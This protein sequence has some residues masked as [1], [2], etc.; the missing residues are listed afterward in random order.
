MNTAQF[1]GRR[2]LRALG[3]VLLVVILVFCA[4]R[5]VPGDPAIL[6]L[7]EQARDSDILRFQ[8]ATHLN[9]PLGIQLK[10]YLGEIL[11]G[12]FGVPYASYFDAPH[13]STLLWDRLPYTLELALAALLIASLIAFP[14]GII[15]ALNPHSALDKL[16]LGFSLM[17]V[18]IP[19]FWLG[20]ILL[21]F[22]SVQLGW[23][24]GPADP[25]SG[26]LHLILPAF[27][28][29]LAMSGKLVRFVRAGVLETSAEE[30]VRVARA[31]GVHG[32]KLAT[33]HILPGALIPVITLMGVQLA[34]LIGGTIVV[35]QVFARPGIGR[36]LMEAILARDY[37]VVQGCVLLI[38]T[39]YV[40]V[41]M[42]V[43]V[44]YA[45]V[46]PRV[47]VQE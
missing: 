45:W 23:F 3:S 7:G 9:Q 24:P 30:Y 36:L 27:T 39:G 16:V 2:G 35:E 5:M 29:G 42:V 40:V 20:P 44:L 34:T 11:N 43:D 13:V 22:F 33:R 37:N 12:T 26:P 15:A 14:L 10:Y 4:L 6:I 31:K 1:L 21:Y 8:E 41:H 46:D 32:Y 18:A 47:S 38:A 28:L 17:G 25:I 19:T